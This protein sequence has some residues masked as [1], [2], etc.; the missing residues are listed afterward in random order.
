MISFK[1]YINES[2]R[3]DLPPHSFYI[4][5]LGKIITLD[6]KPLRSQFYHHAYIPI[7][8]PEDFGLSHKAMSGLHDLGYDMNSEEMRHA[9]ET[10]E[11]GSQYNLQ[12]ALS[13]LGFYKVSYGEPLPGRPSHRLSMETF[14]HADIHDVHNAFRAFRDRYPHLDSLDVN[15][16]GL[17]PQQ[18]HEINPDVAKRLTQEHIKNLS[19]GVLRFTN[20]EDFD[21]FVGVGRKVGRDPGSGVESVPSPAEAMRKAGTTDEPEFIRK[22]RFFQSDSYQ[23][24]G[25]VLSEEEDKPTKLGHL[26]QIGTKMEDADFWMH[27]RHSI[28][29]VGHPTKEYNPEHFGVKVTRPDL[30]DP[31][32]AYYMMQHLANNGYFRQFATGNTNLV[33]IRS[34]HIHNIPISLG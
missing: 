28:D 29:K 22:G 15:V 6:K 8:Q 10:G 19:N 25:G 11:T 20:T 24:Q 9:L 33:N 26:I 4:S 17:N 21:R 2:E 31:R 30:L 7:T 12:K 23:P 5:K 27:R 34:E 14:N 3:R 18:S 1:Q 16:Y 13:K 32:Y